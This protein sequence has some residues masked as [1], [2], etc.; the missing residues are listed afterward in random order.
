MKASSRFVLLALVLVVCGCGGGAVAP[1][2]DDNQQPPINPVPLEWVH[3]QRTPV[4]EILFDIDGFGDTHI[5]VG[6]GGT[7]LVKVGAGDWQVVD[8]EFDTSLRAVEM[9]S[10]KKALVVGNN[11][12]FRTEDAGATWKRSATSGSALRDVSVFGKFAICVGTNTV[13]LSDDEGETWKTPSGN[14]PPQTFVSVS[15]HTDQMATASAI[16]GN[17]WRTEDGGN[18]WVE[19]TNGD[20]Q[21]TAD[22]V[23]FF[24]EKLGSAALGSPTRVYWTEDGGNSWQFIASF[25]EGFI[26]GMEKVDDKTAFAILGTGQVHVTRN[27]GKTWAFETA[28]PPEDGVINAIDASHPTNWFAVGGF[29]FV[30]ESRNAGSTWQQVSQG[31]IGTFKSVAFA[32]AN[33]G[34]AAF[35]PRLVADETALR[36]LDG[37]ATWVPIDA[38]I[39]RPD[40]A[41]MSESGAGL[42]IG[43]LEVSRTT[44]F[45]TNWAAISPPATDALRGAAILSDQIYIVCGD[46]GQVFRTVDGGATWQNVAPAGFD[47]YEDVCF[48]PDLQT[49]VMVGDDTSYRSTDGGVT[50][51]AINVQADAVACISEDVAVAVGDRILRS[52]DRGENW[53]IIATPGRRMRAIAFANELQGVVVGEKGHMFETLDGGLSWNGPDRVT[54]VRLRSVTFVDGLSAIAGGDSGALV[55]GQ[56]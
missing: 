53:T 33:L 41:F 20:L 5:A 56:P 49:V 14:T 47:A 27:A 51:S 43:G 7:I 36:S 26:A 30:S 16:G 13:Q 6:D 21:R 55:F 45:G 9:I 50:W 29:G 48:F 15:H 22:H 42:M 46:N 37:G 32:N 8:R 24:S 34:V 40:R 2:E 38:R 35:T 52:T 12:I 25:G 3:G 28:V 44:N 4:S 23:V 39:D 10:E 54:T 31:R 17:T 19:T 18:T 1:V 11:G